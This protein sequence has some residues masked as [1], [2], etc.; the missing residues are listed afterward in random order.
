MT[1]HDGDTPR[2]TGPIKGNAHIR[3]D[4]GAFMDAYLR[5]REELGK[6][7]GV[8][9]VGFGRKERGGKFTNAMAIEV[10]V[11][12]KKPDDVLSPEER[13]PPTFEG[14][15]TDVRVVPQITHLICDDQTYYSTI[16]GG[17]QIQARRKGSN[18]VGDPGK[19]T[20][21]CIVNKRGKGSGVDN[22][23]LLT[24]YHVLFFPEG[25]TDELEVYHPSAPPPGDASHARLLG[26]VDGDGV[27][28]EVEFTAMFRS[29]DGTL[30]PRTLDY[31]VDAAIA[32][33]D[34]GSTCF[35][36]PCSDDR[37]KF[38]TS[39]L[40]LRGID[41]ENNRITDVRNI[42]GEPDMAIPP[43][44]DFPDPPIG[45]P[46]P[47]PDL[48]LATD[49]N[50]V[51]KVGRTTG[52][53]TGIV[54]CV[55]ATAQDGATS[56]RHGVIEIAFDPAF[57]EGLNH[58]NCKGNFIFGEAGDSGSLIVDKDNKAV[59]LLFGGRNT[60]F[61]TPPSRHMTYA[62]HIG[63]VLEQLGICIPTRGGTSHGTSAAT[64][65]SGIASLETPE[66]L[67]ATRNT[68]VELVSRT[69]TGA[70]AVRRR[71]YG[72]AF[73]PTPPSEQ[74]VARLHAIRDD[75]A[76]TA[77][78]CEL[79]DALTEARRE[80]GYLIRN[81][82]AVKMV[83]HRNRGPAFLACTLNHLRGDDASIPLEIGGVTRRTFLERMRDVLLS[84]GS[85]ALR[86]TIERHA[87]DV[88]L[89]VDCATVDDALVV[90]REAPAPRDGPSLSAAVTHE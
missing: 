41:P 71:A 60:S 36:K 25:P 54:I 72:A 26:P 68:G 12:E 28:A 83:W 67:L 21:G 19:G 48:T 8:V 86:E 84:R 17:I 87:A 74:Q 43:G 29:S 58:T 75:F 42:M 55:D 50:R 79:L 38:D 61:E 18:V 33:I 31:Y 59:G 11:R 65:G 57:G 88:S 5:A 76:A 66:S 89:I 14:Y 2:H 49:A 70:S 73:A 46:Q 23:Y 1:S 7:P 30:H 45:P 39:I 44:D 6:I 85:T 37:V 15:R 35:G 53:T 27:N 51:Y 40:S 13:I 22:V 4:S 69:R 34:P 10:F 78:G 20:L 77:R 47:F 52:K 56:F 32:L 90:L 9:G 63:P 82:R 24:N 62:C 64:D 3:N 16:R 81:E 80:I